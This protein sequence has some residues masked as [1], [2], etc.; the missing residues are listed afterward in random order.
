MPLPND[1]LFNLQWFL[2][3]TGQA[4]GT[5]GMDINV[6]KV[7]DNYSGT[8]IKIGVYDDGVEVTHPDLASNYNGALQ[9][10]IGGSIHAGTPIT[11]N[12]NHGTAVAGL[13]VASGNN[14]LGVVGVAYGSQFGTARFLGADGATAS[15]LLAQ[16]TL[17]DVANHSWGSTRNYFNDAGG[18]ASWATPAQTGR[19]GLG[20]IMVKAAGNERVGQAGGDEPVGRDANDSSY[21]A[22]R[23]A[24]IVGALLNTGFVTEYSSPS[25]ALLISAPGGALATGLD[26]DITTDRVGAAGYN[27]GNG[28]PS[29]QP[30][31]AA[32]NG[33][34]AATPVTSGVAALILQ[35]NPGLGWR[36]M[37]T[38]LAY[39]GRKVGSAMGA[40]PTGA[41][42]D[43][44]QFN[45]AR[46]WNGGGLHFSNDYGFGLIDALTAVRLAETWRIGVPAALTS[47][48][49]QSATAT[50]TRAAAAIPDNNGQSLSYSF[51]ISGAIRIE[52][53]QLNLAL[54][55]SAVGDLRVIL[56]SPGGATSDI[57]RGTNA[58]TAINTSWTFG[59]REFF[60]EA[61]NGTWTLTVQDTGSLGIG[62]AGDATLTVYGA[63]QTAND[64]YVYTN[65]FAQFAGLSGRNVLTDTGGTDVLNAAGVTTALNINLVGGAASQIA[66]QTLTIAAGTVIENAIGGDGADTISG[67]DAANLL[68]GMRDNDRLAG[69]L[70]ADTLTGGAGS[71]TFVFAAGDI[72]AGQSDVITD[73]AAGFDTILVQGARAV[74]QGLA[75]STSAGN[76]TFTMPNSWAFTLNTV[77]NAIVR[78]DFTAALSYWNVGT[79]NPWSNYTD[80]LN[81]SAQ[82]TDQDIINLN[83][84]RQQRHIAQAGT[85]EYTDFFNVGSQLMDQELIFL[86]GN[87]EQRHFNPN[88]DR[89][90]LWNQ[91]TDYFNPLTQ[92]TDQETRFKDGRIAQRHLNQANTQEYTDY[93]TAAS[94]LL[95]QEVVNLNGT[96]EQRHFDPFNQTSSFQ[97]YTDFFNVGSQIVA[98]SVVFD[99]NFQ[100]QTSYSTPGSTLHGTTMQYN[101]SGGLFNTF[102]F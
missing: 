56:T 90:P 3:N 53:I 55:H 35:A 28:T 94:V 91:Y 45:A 83:G 26:Q 89:Y 76:V 15:S 86:A 77:A 36:D 18:D 96:R 32:F 2:K 92:L 66:G 17:Y 79:A 34:S 21:N 29:G 10:T 67:N 97:R 87:R 49:E 7:W 20:V 98:K 54:N 51:T 50:V 73:Y 78:I 85:Q 42:A 1:P 93:V 23:Y 48:N 6:E 101:A 84:T 12:D 62:T 68:L 31:Y 82:I 57:W 80:Y 16:Q 44:W 61:A 95:D 71:D 65:E 69:G 63:T 75:M 102:S 43:I 59:S 37:Q 19:G 99:N 74:M 40:A 81:G 30:D 9:A 39:S 13:I 38:I 58:A 70:G 88:G 64:S 4:G 25:A 72:N 60:G 27:N 24:I 47:A 22:S 5:A 14:N 46:D 100:D 11:A 8:G 33:T 52:D 41:E